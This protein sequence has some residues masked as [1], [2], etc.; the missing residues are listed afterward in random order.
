MYS[1]D[2]VSPHHDHG[3]KGVTDVDSLGLQDWDRLSE[4]GMV[5]WVVVTVTVVVAAGGVDVTPAT[6]KHEHA[7]E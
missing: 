1:E 7:D 3:K 5:P 6:P 2:S 4:V